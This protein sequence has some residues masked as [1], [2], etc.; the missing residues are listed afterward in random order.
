MLALSLEDASYRREKI[1]GHA[2]VEGRRLRFE[3][4]LEL[5]LS[6]MPSG[7]L[8]SSGVLT[9]LR[10]IIHALRERRV[11]IER[12]TPERLELVVSPEYTGKVGGRDRLIARLREDLREVDTQA[13]MVDDVDIHVSGDRARVVQSFL[14]ITRVGERRLENRSRERLELRKEGSLWRFIGGLG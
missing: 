10:A 6:R 3:G 9:D 13:I 4:P 14:M 12:G 5:G 8:L 7:P 2:R 11:A 1:Q